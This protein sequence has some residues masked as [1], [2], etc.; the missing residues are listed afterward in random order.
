LIFLYYLILLSLLYTTVQK[1]KF[2]S[3]QTAPLCIVIFL[4][5][6]PPSSFINTKNRAF[7]VSVLDVGQ[8][9][10][11]L[12]EFPSGF[13][14]L[15]DGGG[16]SYLS[17][18]VGERVIAPYLWKKGISKID[19]IIVT[20]PDSDHYNGLSFIIEHFSPSKIWLNNFVGHD[21][22][23]KKFLWLAK[24]RG[25]V[26]AIATDNLLLRKPPEEIRCIAN[27]SRWQKSEYAR[28]GN[29]KENSGL[30][31][32]VCAQGTCMLFPGDIG[33]GIE[34]LLTE[35]KYPLRCSLLLSPHHGSATSNSLQFLQAAEPEYMI[36]SAGKSRRNIF[37]HPGLEKLCR[38]ND[39]RLLQTA[40]YG[41]IEIVSE[42]GGYRI[43]GHRK[44]KGNPLANL[45]RFLIA[46]QNDTDKANTR[47]KNSTP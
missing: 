37:P 46:R 6:L 30:I 18:G 2:P 9:S 4:F 25:A 3:W 36:V 19:A 22:F 23:F 40:D 7:S 45:R 32:R 5:F 44:L 39:I 11:T 12:L 34:L 28:G 26:T 29:R 41:T 15:I 38:Q 43:Y 17:T 35:K 27:T 24:K 31:I 42:G 14:A 33:K 13:K 16:S 8:G 20:H 21:R 47:V 1:E 10:S